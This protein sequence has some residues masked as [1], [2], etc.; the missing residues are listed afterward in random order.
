LDIRYTPEDGAENI[1]KNI[2]NQLPR[3][4]RLDV[5]S[6]APAQYT[7]PKNTDILKLSAI[8]KAEN[9][10]K[11]FQVLDMNGATDG[12]Y[13]TKRGIPVVVFGIEGAGL[14]QNG[15]WVSIKSV[16]KYISILTEFLIEGI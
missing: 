2:R 5:L 12:N 3:K 13:F 15:E 1:I 9:I 10:I 4:F 16:E 8:L 11:G 14:H 7:N 6:V